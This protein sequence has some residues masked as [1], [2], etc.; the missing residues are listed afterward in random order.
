[1]KP[2][3]SSCAKR[4]ADGLIA[5]ILAAC[6][7]IRDRII[8]PRKI[9]S[10]RVDLTPW[11][12]STL[13]RS[14][15]AV[16]DLTHSADIKLNERVSLRR[17]FEILSSLQSRG[18]ASAAPTGHVY[19]AIMGRCRVIGDSGPAHFPKSIHYLLRGK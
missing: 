19:R 8:C 11:S 2:S 14:C 3:I 5:V 7:I 4:A 9:E 17:P 13:G 6:L 12:R 15:L 16:P 10:T 18:L 1:M